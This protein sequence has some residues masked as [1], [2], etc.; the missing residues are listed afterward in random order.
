M[1]SSERTT[2]SSMVEGAGEV[3]WWLLVS[4]GSAVTCLLTAKFWRK[5]SRVPAARLGDVRGVPGGRRNQYV[6]L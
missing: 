3:L 6:I 4:T 1:G 2:N 5:L